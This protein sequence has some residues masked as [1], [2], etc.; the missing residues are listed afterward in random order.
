VQGLKVGALMIYASPFAEGFYSRLGAIRIG[1]G[2]L[3]CSPEVMRP[4]FLFIVPPAKR[5]VADKNSN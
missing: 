5:F 2:P 1:E 4:H 3:S